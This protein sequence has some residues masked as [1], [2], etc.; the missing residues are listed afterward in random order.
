MYQLIVCFVVLTGVVS[1][2]TRD[3]ILLPDIKLFVD[4]MRRSLST[5]GPS[6][7]IHFRITPITLYVSIRLGYTW[8][9][10]CTIRLDKEFCRRRD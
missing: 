7:G 2:V 4:V 3:I 10:H 1:Y 6:I 8:F 5:Y 9:N